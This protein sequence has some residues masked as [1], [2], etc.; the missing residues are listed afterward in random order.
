VSYSFHPHNLLNICHQ[1]H[2]TCPWLSCLLCH[3]C[4]LVNERLEN[5]LCWS[6]LVIVG[7]TLTVADD[8]HPFVSLLG[9][10][11]LL[12]ANP[13]H[14][15]LVVLT[16]CFQCNTVHCFHFRALYMFHLLYLRSNF[17]YIR[18]DAWWWT[19]ADWLWMIRNIPYTY[20]PWNSPTTIV[21]GQRSRKG[22]EVKYGSENFHFMTCAHEAL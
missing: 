6:Q 2:H 13:T 8:I 20:R 4:W 14:K 1:N 10:P 11:V 12:W 17:N 7:L 21:Q 16:T 22:I 15:G 5:L 19:S 18:L 9:F 3:R